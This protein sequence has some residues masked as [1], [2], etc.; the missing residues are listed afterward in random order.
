MVSDV[1]SI[2]IGEKF[3]SKYDFRETCFGIVIVDN[4]LMVVKKEINI[5]LSGEE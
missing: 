2:T 3:D 1:K 4:K 5:L